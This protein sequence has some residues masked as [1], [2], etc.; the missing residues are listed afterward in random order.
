MFS[1]TITLL[2]TRG[3]DT[4]HKKSNLSSAPVIIDIDKEESEALC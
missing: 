3:M 2:T 4:Q 1:N